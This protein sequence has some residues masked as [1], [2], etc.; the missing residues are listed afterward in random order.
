MSLS[1]KAWLDERVEQ[2][3]NAK[4][5]VAK[6][7][8]ANRDLT[9]TEANTVDQSLDRVKQID[10]QVAGREMVNSV[11]SLG[12]AED[13]PDRPGLFTEFDK[14]GIVQAIKS[15]TAFRTTV[16]SKALIGETGLLPTSGTGVVP[17][18]HP[19]TMFALAALF[20][21]EPASG[22]SIRYYVMDN[23]AAAVVGE[24]GIKPDAGLA[25]TPADAALIKLATVST[26][27]DELQADAP[28]LISAIAQELQ[29]AVTVAENNHVIATLTAA[30]G[31]LTDTSTEAELLDVFADQIAA[32][33]S[34]HGVVPS[35]IVVAPS[36]LSS[37]RKARGVPTGNYLIARCPQHQ[38]RFT[39][40]R[41]FPPPQALPGP[42]GSSA[43]VPR[44]CS[45]VVRSPSR[46]ASPATTGSA[47]RPTCVAR[48]A[49]CSQFSAPA[50]SARSRSAAN[51]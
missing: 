30:S 11:M 15:R 5:T 35:A 23:A 32:Q 3:A 42:R 20:A 36:V 17:G 29:S 38:R 43:D 31:V 26:I 19:G 27:S 34:L 22:P 48:N 6:A 12:S 37:L 51:P 25:I 8:A 41:W 9:P 28:Y 40:C 49:S 14:S 33:T 7:T 4:N 39:G 18:L 2:V 21:T 1:T 24:G 16:P 10:K 46:S 50:W 44:P 13:D 45:G 47:T